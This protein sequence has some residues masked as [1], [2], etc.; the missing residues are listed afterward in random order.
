[1]DRVLFDQALSTRRAL[2]LALGHHSPEHLSPALR[3]DLVERLKQI[4][5]DDPDA[6]IHGAAGW[7]LRRWGHE[8]ALGQLDREAAVRGRRP[9]DRWFTNSVGMTLSVIEGPVEFTMGSPPSEPEHEALEVL[10]RRVIPRRFAIGTTEVTLAQFKEF[11]GG[12]DGTA[13]LGRQRFNSDPRGPVCTPSWYEAAAFCNWLSLRE[14]LQP[15]YEPDEQ[16]RYGPGMRIPADVWH[17]S[18]YRL[19]TEAEW[20]Y[21]CRAGTR[22]GRYFGGRSLLDHYAWFNMNAD[23][24]A[25]P[26]GILLPNDLG[27]FDMIGNVDEWCEDRLGDYQP[28]PDGKVIDQRTAESVLD[29]DTSHILRGGYFGDVAAHL[30]AAHRIWNTPHN[31]LGAY[32]FRVARTIP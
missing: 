16:G 22:T 23:G 14:N 27:L 2:I 29:K 12:K 28:G 3:E 15:C 24:H 13:F 4:Y 20:E 8:A 25:H 30:N 32:G 6:G 9:G 21:A 31:Q 26:C 19:P 18:G 7:A 10:H 1:M 17:R 5:R 11:L